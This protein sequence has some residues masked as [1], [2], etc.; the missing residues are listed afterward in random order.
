MAPTKR[1]LEEQLAAM[2][3]ELDRA[4]AAATVAL[5]VRVPRELRDRVHALA[6]AREESVQAT[7]TWALETALAD[8]ENTEK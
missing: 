7:V 8:Q 6:A 5:S 1:E 4:R 3:A 2:Q